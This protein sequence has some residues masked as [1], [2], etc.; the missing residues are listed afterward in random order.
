[1]FRKLSALGLSAA[2]L[3]GGALPASAAVAKSGYKYDSS[4]NSF[5][6]PYVTARWIGYASIKGP[7]RDYYLY[8]STT[9]W[10]NQS[11][12]GSSNGGYWRVSVTDTKSSDGALSDNGTYAYCAG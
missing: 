8:Y 9:S 5:S 7:G 6:S 1:M 2:L 3:F 11:V 4:C 10:A 12:S